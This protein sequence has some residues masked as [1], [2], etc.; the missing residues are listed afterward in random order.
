M[1]NYGDLCITGLRSFDVRYP[2]SDHKDGSDAMNKDPDYSA[3]Y[4]ILDTNRPDVKGNGFSFTIGRGNEIVVHAINALAP[5][6]VGRKMTDICADMAGFWMSLVRGDSQ[7]RWLGECGAVHLGRA[8]VVN[9]VWDLWARLEEKPLWRLLVDMSP[10]HLVSCIPFAGITDA[11]TPQES[12]QM[13]RAMREGD[14]AH[15]D[16]LKRI[17]FAEKQGVKAY[18]TSCGWLGYPDD[19]IK[20]LCEEAVA[21][22][23]T[24]IK[25]KVG[26]DLEDDIRRCKIVRSVIGYDKGMNLMVD[27][28]QIWDVPQAIE[29][30]KKLAEFRPRWIEEPVAPDDVYGHAAVGRAVRPL[31]IG[32]ATGEH[33]QNRVMFKQFMFAEQ[34]AAIDFVQVDAARVAGVNENLAIYLMAK[35]AGKLVCPHAGGVGLCELVQ[36]LSFFDYICVAGT[37]E[38][39]VTEFV[40]HLH[41][42]FVDPCVVEKSYY[43]APKQPGYA[44]MKLESMLRHVYPS[45]EVWT[46]RLKNNAAAKK[47]QE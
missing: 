32:I 30:M 27:A 13:L 34:G 23:W 12:V 10:E 11:I 31:G 26:R 9:A 40:D 17:E 36:H 37:Q 44:A 14:A 1:Y 18:T 33:C 39:R 16:F 19:K 21:D 7:L 35:K 41:E 43:R 3:A 28:N 6:V 45:G 29:W 25:I 15:K 2:T 20:R 46:A 5:L 24:D 4:L 38:G 22:G 8:A 42:A 47:E